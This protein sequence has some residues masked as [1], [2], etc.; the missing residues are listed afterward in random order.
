MLTH[1]EA[2]SLSGSRT[3]WPTAVLW[4]LDGTIV[5]TEPLWI[6][7]EFALASEYGA[8]WSREQALG[9]VGSDLRTSALTIREQM[10]IPLSSEQIVTYLVDGVVDRMNHEPPWRPGAVELLADLTSSGVRC[11]LVTMSYRK[12]ADPVLAALPAHTFESVVTGDEVQHGKPHPEPYRTAAAALGVA[13]SECLAIEDSDVGA[14][15]AIAA[16]CPVL[17]VPNHVVVPTGIDTR[18]LSGLVRGSLAQFQAT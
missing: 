1:G 5:D 11:G 14:R 8:R 12:L 15:S 9:L 17:I 16:G 10:G 2:R 4:D 7:T 13:A 3:P 6:A 18:L